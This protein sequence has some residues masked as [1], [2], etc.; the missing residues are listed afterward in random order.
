[1][2]KLEY[3]VPYSHL[4][5]TQQ[6]LFAA[7]AGQIG[8][9]AECCWVTEGLG[10]FRPLAGATP[11]IGQQGSVQKEPEMKVELVFSRA[12]KQAVVTALKQSHPYETPAYQLISVET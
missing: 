8:D 9:Y 12:L 5:I 2:L 4:D 7:G 10:Q 1:M 11:F 6:A 3:Y